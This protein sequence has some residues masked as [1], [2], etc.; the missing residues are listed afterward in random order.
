MTRTQMS[1]DGQWDLFVD[2]EQ[3]LDAQALA[4]A[5]EPRSVTVPGPWQVQFDDLRERGGTVWYRRSFTTPDT[6]ITDPI[7][8]IR[9]GAVDYFAQVWLNG[10]EIGNHEGGYLPFE[11]ALT[12]IKA[13]DSNE[14]IVRVVDPGDN[15][16]TFDEFP[17]DE[18]PHGK[19][20]WYGAIGGIW[21]SVYVEARAATHLKRVAITPDVAGEQALIE[22]TLNDATAQNGEVRYNLTEPNGATSERSFSVGAGDFSL[23]TALPVPDAQLWDIDQPNLYQLQITL[24][25]DG[26]TVD[27]LTETFGMRTVGIANR[28]ITLNGRPIYLRSALDQD[29]YPQG[30]YTVFSDEELDDQFAKAKHLGLNC[31]RTHIKITDP[32]YYAAADR[33]GVLIWTELPNW[34][35]L[36]FATKERARATLMGMVERDWNHPS[37]VIWTIINEDWGTELMVNPDHRE[38]LSET[39]D[40]M[41]ALDPTRLVVDNSACH[42]NFHV[43]SDLEDFHVY[44]SV[45]DHY[46]SWKRWVDIF[47]ERPDWSYA[48]DY[49]NVENWRTYNRDPWAPVARKTLPV[50]RRSKEEPL[51]L[52]EFGN[53]GLPD[54]NN[55]YECYNGEPWWF[56][57]GMD[58][59]AGEVYPHGIEHR[60]HLFHLDKV[61]GTLSNLAQVSQRM[62]FVAM[63]YEIEQMRRRGEIVGYVITEFTDVN[64]ECN[65]LLDLCRNPK[66]YHDIFHEVNGDDVIVPEW[67]RTA[68]WSGESCQ[69]KLFLSHYSKHDLS[70]ST[71]AWSVN[72][73]EGI[74]GSFPTQSIQ[75]ASVIEVGTIAFE[76][77]ALDKSAALVIDLTLS[78]AGGQV[79]AHNQQTIYAFPRSLEDVVANA[80]LLF[81]A[82]NT[83]AKSFAALGYKATTNRNDADVVV[84]TTMTDDLR[85]YLQEGG[86]IL[87]LAESPDAL[88][89]HLAGLRIERRNGSRWQGDWASNFN[90]LRQDTLFGDIPTGNTLDF[91]FAD[92]IPDHVILGLSARDYAEEVHAGLTVGWLHNT[93]GLV[94]ERGFGLGRLLTSTFNLKE[95]IGNNPVATVML[96]DLVRH[97]A[98]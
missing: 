92:I 8:V 7:Y 56:E 78:D 36:T 27:S 25:V 77:P 24:V 80:P 82:D 58:R 90:W 70:N 54:V 12:G 47:A 65:G 75:H 20:S 37:I 3:Q 60:F 39:Y 4:N 9:F 34:I 29:Y 10:T 95:N 43:S 32:R 72:G 46:R 79:L 45:P 68:F 31:L 23:R 19:Q 6:T 69:I 93:V 83:L 48:F 22:V 50:V 26:E 59:G 86:R 98:R 38:W 49:E 88:Q 14:L 52:S 2:N 67:E 5:G 55:L 96:H 57:T 89:T 84:A 91:A 40:F 87:W 53:W 17:F 18:I 94:A 41:K 51:I 62:Q 1:L 15:G 97:A 71:L 16:P 30:Q 21:Q 64:W 63:K 74:G 73:V 44:Y 11:L 13:G 33:A 28:H 42:G 85:W 66:A 81:F 76:V 61:F 35:T